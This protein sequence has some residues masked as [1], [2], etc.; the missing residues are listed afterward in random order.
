VEELE[1]DHFIDARFHARQRL[2]C[3]ACQDREPRMRKGPPQLADRREGGDEIPDMVELHRQ[4]P[5]DAAFR[6]TRSTGEHQ[7][8][9]LMIGTEVVVLLEQIRVKERIALGEQLAPRLLEGAEI[10]RI[11][12]LGPACELVVN[13]LRIRRVDHV[14]AGVEHP[15]AVVEV[16]VDHIMRLV[17]ASQCFEAGP[18]HQHAG[19][20]DACHVALHHREPEIAGVVFG[21]EA[22]GVARTA[23]RGQ[24]NTRMLHLA[25][26]IEE[27]GSNHPD[28]R[29][30]CVFQQRVKPV[31]FDHLDVV[32]EKQQELAVRLPGALVV[33]A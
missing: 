33:E 10:A 14:L 4:D 6:Q 21:E 29:A 23:L 19:P 7:P 26:G 11:L 30:I 20:S 2:C 22:E 24:E 32:V 5:G 28:I 8:G 3:P 9:R 18:P 15:Q 31:R 16:V 12:E 1:L 25:V 17:E 27:L 13:E